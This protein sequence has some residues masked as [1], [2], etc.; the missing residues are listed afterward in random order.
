MEETRRATELFSVSG[1]EFFCDTLDNTIVVRRRQAYEFFNPGKSSKGKSKILNQFKPFRNLV[2]S[3]AYQNSPESFIELKNVVDK[4][5]SMSRH[6]R[7]LGKELLY[8]LLV[9]LVTAVKDRVRT[10]NDDQFPTKLKDMWLKEIV[11]DVCNKHVIKP[12]VSGTPQVRSRDVLVDL[13][14]AEVVRIF[15]PSFF[16]DVNLVRKLVTT[17][18]TTEKL[19]SLSLVTPELVNFKKE[20]I[21]FK[22][23]EYGKKRLPGKDF[24]FAAVSSSIA[25]QV[26]MKV[27][28]KVTEAFETY[29]KRLTALPSPLMVEKL[30]LLW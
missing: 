11:L 28:N 2:H 12:E 15:G 29:F 18:F 30:P 10:P 25:D 17:L 4:F 5:F 16:Y 1:M 24:G 8:K 3:K 22:Q 23:R 26:G 7:D 14:K 13:V 19:P 6:N 9:D 20:L 27:S 21:H